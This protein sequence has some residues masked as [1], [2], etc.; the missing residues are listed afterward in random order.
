VYSSMVGVN[1]AYTKFLSPILNCK[2][3]QHM[4]RPS[5]AVT[6]RTTRRRVRLL[7]RPEF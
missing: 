4:E 5:R 2:A 1:R 3:P 6:S 7:V